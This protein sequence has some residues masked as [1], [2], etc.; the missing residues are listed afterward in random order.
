MLIIA[1]PLVLYCMLPCLIALAWWRWFYYKR[2]RYLYS[3]IRIFDS[4]KTRSPWFYEAIVFTLRLA[5]LVMLC[6]ALC[7]MRKP[8]EQTK[9]SVEGVDILLVIDVSGSM[10]LFDDLNDKRSRIAVAR[11]EALNFITRRTNDPIGI[12]LFANGVVSRCPLTLDK[13]ILTE[14]MQEV[15]LGIIDHTGTLLSRAILTAAARL[16]NSSAKSKIMIV[17]TD[18]EPSEGDSSPEEAVALAKKIGIKIYTIGIGSPEG[19]F[20]PTLLGLQR[21]KSALNVPLLKMIAENTGGQFFEAKNPA[22]LARIY[23]T[24]D[25]LEKHENEMPLFMHYYEYFMLFLWLAFFLLVIECVICSTVW[26]T[27]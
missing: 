15:T 9:I 20:M 25:S 4:V 10:Q 6:F 23:Q 12:V 13:N 27:L 17:L 22:E 2:P 21:V 19:G 1:Y 5:A 3:S 16:K 7:R 24:I 18:G 11:S 8:E 26:L 14:L